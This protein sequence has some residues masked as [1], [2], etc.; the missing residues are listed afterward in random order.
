[1]AALRQQTHVLPHG[2][3]F[4]AKNAIDVGNGYKPVDDHN[5]DLLCGLPD[6]AVVLRLPESRADKDH[7]VHPL[8][9]KQF[10]ILLFI[11]QPVSGAAQKRIKPV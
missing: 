3:L 2:F 10:E 5:G 8:L 7:G 1:M 9:Q 6:M 11:R 4:I